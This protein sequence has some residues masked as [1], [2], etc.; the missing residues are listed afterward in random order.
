MEAPGGSIKMIC[1]YEAFGSMMLI[2][3]I[4]LSSAYGTL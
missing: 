3:S 1:L 2:I 4:N